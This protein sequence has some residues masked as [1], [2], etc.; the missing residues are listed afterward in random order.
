MSIDLG[1]GANKLT[2]ANVANTG[3]VSNVNTL[4]GGTGADADHPRHRHGQR[5]RQPRLRQRTR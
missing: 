1:A 3:T 2:L 5:Q 4:I